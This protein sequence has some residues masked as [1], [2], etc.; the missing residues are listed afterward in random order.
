MSN[1]FVKVDE[2]SDVIVKKKILPKNYLKLDVNKKEE[3]P[4]LTTNL[5]IF[6]LL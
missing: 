2:S 3:F 1:N 4:G 6:E 5:I